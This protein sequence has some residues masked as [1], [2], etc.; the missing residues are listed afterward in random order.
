MKYKGLYLN[1]FVIA[2]LLSTLLKIRSSVCASPSNFPTKEVK[3][4]GKEG[5]P[6]GQ[7][8]THTFIGSRIITQFNPQNSQGENIKLNQLA[9]SLGYDHFNWVNYVEK[10]PYGITDQ[11]GQQ[12]KIPYNDPPKGGYRYDSADRLPFYWDLV[13]CDRCKPRHHFQNP[14]NLSQF[15]L[16]FEDSPAD[17][18]LQPGEAVEF[19]THLVGVK[20]YDLQQQTAEWEILHTFRWKLTNPHPTLSQVSLI[21]SDVALNKLSPLLLSKMQLDGA[22][23]IAR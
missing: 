16:V 13:K 9:S 8:I 7:N 3:S 1:I 14:H 18:R 23:L 6:Y 12:L 19:T 20:Q 17:Y 11:A 22:I 10:D 21:E 5:F 2:I 15:E 4:L